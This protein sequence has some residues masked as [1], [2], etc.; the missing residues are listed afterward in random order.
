MEDVDKQVEK[1]GADIGA[2]EIVIDGK[3]VSLE[4][5]KGEVTPAKLQKQIEF[6]YR[7]PENPNYAKAMALA[8]LRFA[9]TRA[10]L[11]GQAKN[12]KNEQQ[13]RLA[14]YLTTYY[15]Y[16]P[17]LVRRHYGTMRIYAEQKELFKTKYGI[18]LSGNKRIVELEGKMSK[19][20]AVLSAKITARSRITNYLSMMRFKQDIADELKEMKD[21]IKKAKDGDVEDLLVLQRE[22]EDAK[23]PV[24][25]KIEAAIGDLRKDKKDKLDALEKEQEEYHKKKQQFLDGDGRTDGAIEVARKELPA[26]VRRDFPAPDKEEEMPKT[27]NV[28]KLNRREL[29]Q[30]LLILDDD[31]DHVLSCR[32]EVPGLE[33]PGVMPSDLLYGTFF[34]MTIDH[35]NDKIDALKPAQDKEHKELQAVRAA[36]VELAYGKEEKGVVTGGYLSRLGEAGIDD[37]EMLTVHET[38]DRTYAPGAR[39]KRPKE[40]YSDPKLRKKHLDEE[41]E[42]RIANFRGHFSDVLG[43]KVT[44]DKRGKAGLLEG[45]QW[46]TLGL[47][48]ENMEEI[49]SEKGRKTALSA[50]ELIAIIRNLPKRLVSSRW[51]E[52][53]RES[54]MKNIRKAAGLPEDFDM[55]KDPLSKLTK[56]QKET[57][58]KKINT[59]LK[60]I[61]KFEPKIRKSFTD[62]DADWKLL[63]YMRGNPAMDSD[64]LMNV[65]PDADVL[66]G[67]EKI[68]QV[69]IDKLI[70]EGTKEQKA[71]A[72]RRLFLQ[73]RANWGEYVK[74]AREFNLELHDVIAEHEDSAADLG[75]E[76]AWPYWLLVLAGHWGVR[77]AY[78]AGGGPLSFRP[79]FPLLWR[80]LVRTPIR[81]GKDYIWLGRKGVEGVRGLKNWVT[82]GSLSSNVQRFRAL[83]D[84]IETLRASGGNAVRVA[85]LEAQQLECQRRIMGML[86]TA[87]NKL[88]ATQAQAMRA[89]AAAELLGRKATLSMVEMEFLQKLHNSPKD[90][91]LAMECGQA[92]TKFNGLSKAVQAPHLDAIRRGSEA[93]LKALG[94]GANDIA[95]FKRLNAARLAEKGRLFAAARQAG[96]WTGPASEFDHLCRSGIAGKG[97]V[98]VAGEVL[99]RGKDAAKGSKLWAGVGMGVQA[100]MLLVDTWDMVEQKKRAEKANGEIRKQLDQFVKDSDGKFF[101]VDEKEEKYEYWEKGKAQKDKGKD[102]PLFTV[103]LK[104]FKSETGAD[105][106]KGRMAADVAGLAVSGLLLAGKFGRVSNPIG[107]ATIAIEVVVRTAIEGWE[108]STYYEVVRKCPMIILA[109]LGGTVTS[110]G[111]SEHD[112]PKNRLSDIFLE[113]DG[114]LRKKL[115][116]SAFLTHTAST[117]TDLYSDIMWGVESPKDYD[118]LQKDFEVDIL[119]SF[120]S[121]TFLTMMRAN[122]SWGDW[123][124]LRV[125]QHTFAYV[126][127]E[128]LEKGFERTARF[129]AGYRQQKLRQTYQKELEGIGAELNMPLPKDE[130]EQATKLER[131]ANLQIKRKVLEQILFQQ[132]FKVVLG[133]PLREWDEYAA[134]NG[135]KPV[136]GKLGKKMFDT[137]DRAAKLHADTADK[138][139][140]LTLPTDSWRIIM[141][142]TGGEDGFVETPLKV[143]GLL[144]EDEEDEYLL[145]YNRNY[146]VDTSGIPGLPD[147]VK[148]IDSRTETDLNPIPEPTTV[149]PV[150]PDVPA[151]LYPD[152]AARQIRLAR[153]IASLGERRIE[154]RVQ[155]FKLKAERKKK[156][157]EGEPDV[158]GLGKK[159]KEHGDKLGRYFSDLRYREIEGKAIR[160]EIRRLVTLTKEVSDRADKNLKL[161]FKNDEGLRTVLLRFAPEQQWLQKTLVFGTGIDVSKHGDIEVMGLMLKSAVLLRDIRAVHIKKLENGDEEEFEAEI[162]CGTNLEA[163]QTDSLR[164]VRQGFVRHKLT[165]AIESGVWNERWNPKPL[166]ETTQRVIDDLRRAESADLEGALRDGLAGMRDI[167]RLSRARSSKDMLRQLTNDPDG[168]PVYAVSASGRL[169]MLR[170][171]DGVTSYQSIDLEDVEAWIKKAS[172]DKA[173]AKDFKLKID[174]K[175]WVKIDAA[176]AKK[177]RDERIDGKKNV[178]L[179]YQALA[180]ESLA[181]PAETAYKDSSPFD[182]ILGL[183]TDA[184]GIPPAFLVKLS[185]LYDLITPLDNDERSFVPD[186]RA[187]AYHPLIRHYRKAIG[188]PDLADNHRPFQRKLLQSLVDKVLEAGDL[189]K[190]GAADKIVAA[191]RKEMKAGAFGP[192]AKDAESRLAADLL[193]GLNVPLYESKWRFNPKNTVRVP[194]KAKTRVIEDSDTM[195]ARTER[196]EAAAVPIRPT[197]GPA[198]RIVVADGS[199]GVAIKKWDRQ[200]VTC[201]YGRSDDLTLTLPGSCFAEFKL[202]A[203]TVGRASTEQFVMKSNQGEVKFW[204]DAESKPGRPPDLIVKIEKPSTPAEER[205][206][207]NPKDPRFPRRST[208][209][210]VVSKE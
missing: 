80:G 180:A 98:G 27:V 109:K 6:I 132:G 192:R 207:T 32:K 56:E 33:Q 35:I 160:D 92:S 151:T 159:F 188:E 166:S 154:L 135:G 185:R 137:L 44:G 101:C 70:K 168:A 1:L 9:Q 26:S 124:K 69:Y 195:A 125:D 113:K 104:D 152:L 201:V 131:R 34:L 196:E 90:L 37:L 206:V 187:A 203:R 123:S 63:Q 68:D 126:E 73:M 58:Q 209:G 208:S 51:A 30:S 198:Q 108:Y 13:K 186:D 77:F 161:D 143:K 179:A 191:L 14:N 16:I 71:A 153:E 48:G 67:T 150:E 117:Q 39:R 18:D 148:A 174:P 183:R 189:S 91:S 176:I 49:W 28:S 12:A 103:R 81:M 36:L 8:Q 127:K 50:L 139:N 142:K 194:I 177:M 82:G 84:E 111:K 110:T 165:E 52:S 53:A 172:G 157:Q 21:A 46:W 140:E 120:I 57:F 200:T 2:G 106:A 175:K 97:N 163:Q 19:Y 204:K 89:Q 17:G 29:E 210:P 38:F 121:T 54:E 190:A 164:V 118:E 78:G 60:A 170:T 105:A 23:D 42:N 87:E 199:T 147:K 141:K 25:K 85:K 72:Y 102:K 79:I 83:A 10:Q 95:A 205:A 15:K 40:L 55:L 178:L 115:L 100:L 122:M 197:E 4:L 171:V 169:L 116:F 158:A 75:K 66:K 145:S 162:V 167:D 107:W 24:A 182:R 94:Y 59:T 5:P 3:R 22:A 64:T 119:P 134:K 41:V 86:N 133:R 65:K 76:G 184:G 47:S 96:T 20:N 112:L 129:F 62:I 93:E 114:K 181:L 144:T 156:L 74:L 11:E 128:D 173:Y 7:Q 193:E 99:E 45:P 155:D 136:H 130:K 202:G 31:I 61:K 43:S 88:P 146:N 149:V 138:L